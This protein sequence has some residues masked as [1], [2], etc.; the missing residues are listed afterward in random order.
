M[1]ATALTLVGI[2][3]ISLLGFTI[4]AWRQ[5]RDAGPEETEELMRAGVSLRRLR[6]GNLAA[7]D[8]GSLVT[9]REGM[10]MSV[11]R[12][13]RRHIVPTRTI[14]RDIC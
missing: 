1:I 14:S 7:P 12:D 4:N 11:D 13:G 5:V 2:G 9:V 10:K 6:E 3:L 8:S